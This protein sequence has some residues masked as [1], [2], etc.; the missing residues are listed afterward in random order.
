MGDVENVIKLA[1][2]LDYIS[3]SGSSNNWMDANTNLPS[4]TRALFFQK[5]LNTNLFSLELNYI[6][7]IEIPGIMKDYLR[8]DMP[9]VVCFTITTSA[10][11]IKL[12]NSSFE[13]N[14]NQ[15]QM[16]NTMNQFMIM[17]QSKESH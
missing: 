10:F 9:E 2:N 5:L 8:R 13:G 1:S 3:F 14:M 6:S 11:N 16:T 7:Q 15:Q 17:K 12:Q 4:E